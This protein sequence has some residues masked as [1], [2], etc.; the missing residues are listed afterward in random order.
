MQKAPNDRTPHRQPEDTPPHP[1]LLRAGRAWGGGGRGDQCPLGKA[2]APGSRGRCQEPWRNPLL[3]HEPEPHC[4]LPRIT[5]C[6]ALQGLWAV[7][8]VLAFLHSLHT[9]VASPLHRSPHTGTGSCHSLQ[10]WPQA[11]V[12][13]SAL[14][15]GTRGLPGCGRAVPAAPS[16]TTLRQSCGSGPRASRCA[17]SDGL[18]AR[19][20]LVPGTPEEHSPCPVP[21]VTRLS[22]TS[23]L[24]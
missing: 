17:F 16:P 6:L 21:V 3:S 8:S 1:L 22:S 13:L 15:Q 4:A 23:C 18:P 7:E 19:P 12:C 5:V 11:V 9:Y 20:C 2:V 14:T 10:S 24:G